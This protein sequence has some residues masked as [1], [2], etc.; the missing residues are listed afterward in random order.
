LR[1]NFVE[2]LKISLASVS[3]TGLR[4]DTVASEEALRPEGAAGLP[5]IEA[6][7]QGTLLPLDGEYLFRGRVVGVFNRPCDRCLRD[8]VQTLDLE[9]DWFYEAGEPSDA[10]LAEGEKY[11]FSRGEL[12]LA[13]AVW[14]ELVLALPAKCV[15]EVTEGCVPAETFAPPADGGEGAEDTGAPMH[16]GFAQLR[17]LFP[18]L[19]RD[20]SK[21]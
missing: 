12:D 18:D 21:E 20:K 4:V 8:V 14:E 15:C 16:S 5:L 7:V 2:S 13:P 1:G 10:E 9:V 11:V 17:E 19:T 6:R 3:D